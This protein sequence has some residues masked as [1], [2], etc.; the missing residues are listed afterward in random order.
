MA[1]NAY[2]AF[3]TF[4]EILHFWAKERPDGPAF[5][6]EGRITTYAEADLLTRQLIALLQSRGI[7]AGD[8]IAWLGKNRDIYFLIYI[9]AARMGAVMV[10]IGWRLAPPEVRYILQD[11]G[12][13][14]LFVGEG[15]EDHAAKWSKP[16][17]HAL[18]PP[19]WI[20]PPTPRPARMIRCSSSTLRERR[21]TRRARS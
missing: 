7:A 16:K 8:R 3:Q 18:L 2:H 9:A 11:T 21:A 20:L 10:P 1:R 15:C 6:Q 17:P 13:K 5:D 12:A 4:D 14:V 19:G